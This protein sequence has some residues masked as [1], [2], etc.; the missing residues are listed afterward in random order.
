MVS[1]EQSFY[2]QQSGTVARELLGAYLIHHSP[3]GTTIG[4][5][6]ETEAYGGPEDKACH[7][8]KGMTPRTRVMFGPGGYTYVYLIYGM[9]C[10]FNVVTGSEGDGQAV[11]VRAVRPVDGLALMAERRKTAKEDNL[12]SGPGK[13]C[14]AFGITREYSGL[15]LASQSLYLAYGERVA[16][17][18]VQT[19]PRINVDYAGAAKDFP[20]RFVV[21]G[22]KFISK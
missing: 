4:Q 12:C 5:I 7:A 3:Q 10:C 9:Y 8:W 20:W 19:T 11:L 22:S 16:D 2:E 21:K 15:S 14:Q 18:Q 17:F 6:V 13:L 1:Y